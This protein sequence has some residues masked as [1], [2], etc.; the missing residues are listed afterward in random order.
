[1]RLRA[2]GLGP[3]LIDGEQAFWRSAGL[4]MQNIGGFF[5]MLA[6]AWA[7]Q[8]WGRRSALYGSLV[9]SF[10]TTVLVFRN[11]REFEH[12]YWMLALMGFGQMAVY[13]VYAIYLS[14][15]FPTRLLLALPFLP[16][17]PHQPLPE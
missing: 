12:V 14:E 13:A 4:L 15:L 10:A 16:E 6:C 17:T 9:L 11:L 1:M 5:G 3:G 2:A 7:A 8:P